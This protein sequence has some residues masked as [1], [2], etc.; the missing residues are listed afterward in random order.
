MHQLVNFENYVRPLMKCGCVSNCWI[1]EDKKMIH[2][3]LTHQEINIMNE[4]INLI[5]RKAQCSYCGKI[6]DSSLTLP[7]FVYQKDQKFDKYCCDKCIT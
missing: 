2:F 5:D 4:E 6:T 3:C 7:F 1:E